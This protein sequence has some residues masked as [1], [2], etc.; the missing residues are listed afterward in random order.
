MREDET[1][2]EYFR[3]SISKF[4]ELQVTDYYP[5]KNANECTAFEVKKFRH[6]FAFS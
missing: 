2:F 5:D 4:F 1:Y 6:N 3:M